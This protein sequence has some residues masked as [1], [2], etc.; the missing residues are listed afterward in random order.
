MSDW[1]SRS[2]GTAYS[3]Q[4]HFFFFYLFAN[5]CPSLPA[6]AGN[7]ATINLLSCSS[8]TQ[9]C[10][11]KIISQCYEK[12]SLRKQSNQNVLTKWYSRLAVCTF[13]TVTMTFHEKLFN[14]MYLHIHG[15]SSLACR[16]SD[17]YP[18][19]WMYEGS[20]V[21]SDYFDYFPFLGWAK[22]VCCI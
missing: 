18:Q 8:V 21:V 13:P 2:S 12:A 19:I 3:V 1:R 5:I 14:K 20:G 15:H 17:V 10:P 9:R 11:L 4:R 16:Q 22:I 7:L 6:F